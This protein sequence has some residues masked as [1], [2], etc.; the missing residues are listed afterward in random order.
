VGK[1]SISGLSGEEKRPDRKN[2][3]RKSQARD[4]WEKRTDGTSASAEIQPQW[5]RSGHGRTPSMN[6]P[7]EQD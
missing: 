5:Q 3:R 6:E 1:V 7:N 2:A 4:T